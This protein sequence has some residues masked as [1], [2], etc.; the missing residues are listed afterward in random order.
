[1]I[2]GILEG[3]AAAE[4]EGDEVHGD[5]DL[6]GAAAEQLRVEVRVAE[7]D[8]HAGQRRRGQRKRQP[9]GRGLAVQQLLDQRGGPLLDRPG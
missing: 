7:P 1:M 5:V 2:T 4:E 6:G 8:D 3:R 9:A